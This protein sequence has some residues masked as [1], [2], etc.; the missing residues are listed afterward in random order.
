MIPQGSTPRCAVVIVHFGD[1]APTASCVEAVLADPSAVARQ[2]VVVDNSHSLAAGALGGGVRVLEP[3]GNLGYGAGLNAGVASLGD[4]LG[5]AIVGLNHDVTIEPGFLAAA[6]E[7]LSLPRVGAAAGPLELARP[8]GE[9]WYAGGGVNF[10]TGTVWQSRRQGDARRARHVGFLTGAAVAIRREAWQAVGGFD[11]AYFLYNEDL[12]LCLRLR[13]RGWR[14]RFEPRMRAVHAL[15]AAT[16]SERRSPLYLEQ[17]TRTR[18]RPFRPL[19]YRLYLAVVHSLWVAVRA[20]V[21]QA[22]GDREGVAALLRGHRYA[23]ATLTQG[24]R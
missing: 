3:E 20:S 9:L 4:C 5:G 19:A 23:L 21:L 8:G 13:R 15:G 11:P 2:V 10:L 6:V 18:L 17:I 24:P 14:L 16:G 22:Q 1:P 7:A 12:D